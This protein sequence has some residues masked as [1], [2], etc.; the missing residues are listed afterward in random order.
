MEQKTI[1]LL[2]E[3]KEKEKQEK[4]NTHNPPQTHASVT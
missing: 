1:H 4:G 3:R 2:V